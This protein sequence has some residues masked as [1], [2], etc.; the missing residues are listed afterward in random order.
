MPNIPVMCLICN[1]S[2]KDSMFPQHMQSVHGGM[3]QSE[4]IMAEKNIPQQPQSPIVLSKETPPSADF[5]EVAEMLDKPKL[6]APPP[7]PN[8]AADSIVN[9]KV[10]EKK[11]L[12]LKYRWEGNCEKC[13]SPIRTI[14]TQVEGRLFATAYCL[15]HED[16]EQIEVA[17]IPIKENKITKETLKRVETVVIENDDTVKP[18]ITV[19]KEVKRHAKR[20]K[21]FIQHKTPLQGPVSASG[22]QR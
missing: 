13:N 2:V 10:E 1:K 14:M 20:P 11:P 5:M 17:P 8:R 12:I 18:I 15:T 16:L 7:V 9:E 22:L 21:S 3:T 6:Q 4:A 19:R